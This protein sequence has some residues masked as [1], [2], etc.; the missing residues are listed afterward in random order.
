MRDPRG[1]DRLRDGSMAMAS[2]WIGR[3]QSIYEPTRKFHGC[4][5]IGDLPQGLRIADE[6]KAVAIDAPAEL[7]HHTLCGVE[8]EIDRH[9]PTKQKIDGVHARPVVWIADEIVLLELHHLF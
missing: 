9:I 6:Q 7:L 1:C 4:K 2:R 8:A 3:R 5:P